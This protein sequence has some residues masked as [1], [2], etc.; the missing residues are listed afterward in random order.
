MLGCAGLDELCAQQP[1]NLSAEKNDMAAGTST[2]C[3]LCSVC[4]MKESTG[5]K[6]PGFLPCVQTREAP[7][8]KQSQ[9]T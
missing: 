1:K 5:L 3:V 7:K 2:L 9:V 8:A 6:N 4:G